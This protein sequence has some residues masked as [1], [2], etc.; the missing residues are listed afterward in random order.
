MVIRKIGYEWRL[1]YGR[2]RKKTDYLI[3]QQ[4]TV[5]SNH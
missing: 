5:F 4:F 1:I 3:A 2:F